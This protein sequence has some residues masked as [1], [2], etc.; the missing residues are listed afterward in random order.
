MPLIFF[1]IAKQ[2][3]ESIPPDKPITNEV[4]LASVKFSL[5][6]VCKYLIYSLIHIV[7]PFLNLSFEGYILSFRIYLLISAKKIGFISYVHHIV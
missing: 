4:F 3:A 1:A 6:Q 2:H 5:I 7:L